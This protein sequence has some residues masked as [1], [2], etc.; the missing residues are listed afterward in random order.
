MDSVRVELSELQAGQRNA[1][2]GTTIDV[3]SLLAAGRYQSVLQL[4]QSTMQD[5]VKLLA[6]EVERRRQAVVE[7]DVQVRILDKLE[8]RQKAEHLYKLQQAEIKE[9]DEIGSQRVAV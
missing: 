1:I 6:T 7:A 5:Q 3:N 2:G 4:Q 9:L 8:D